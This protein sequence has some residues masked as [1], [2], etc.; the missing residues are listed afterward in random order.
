M[1]PSLLDTTPKRKQTRLQN[2]NAH[3]KLIIV[4]NDKNHVRI[5]ETKSELVRCV[6]TGATENQA[7][8][9]GDEMFFSILVEKEVIKLTSLKQWGTGTFNIQKTSKKEISSN[10]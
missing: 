5:L 6:I 10:N 4:V 7:I 8:E 3:L 1:L 9:V 2:T